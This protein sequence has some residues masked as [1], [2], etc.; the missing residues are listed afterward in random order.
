MAKDGGAATWSGQGIG[1][2][3]PNGGVSWR[4]AVIVQSA[5]GS[6]AHV[7]S[8]VIV[9]EFETDANQNTHSRSWEWK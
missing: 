4:G 9:F 6:L 5:T 2:L 8:R 1:R 7:N 3:T